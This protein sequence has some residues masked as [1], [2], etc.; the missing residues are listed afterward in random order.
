[1]VFGYRYAWILT[2]NDGVGAPSLP[3]KHVTKIYQSKSRGVMTATNAAAFEKGIVLSDERSR[4]RASG[5]L[6]TAQDESSIIQ[7]HLKKENSIR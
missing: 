4:L 7:I 1:M 5:Y 2:T 3:K 6:S